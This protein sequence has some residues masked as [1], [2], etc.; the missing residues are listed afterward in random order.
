M[1]I[2]NIKVYVKK[3]ELVID[4]GKPIKLNKRFSDA[5][6]ENI[7]NSSDKALNPIYKVKNSEEFE[8]ICDDGGNIYEELAKH[9]LEEKIPISTQ[10]NPN[11]PFATLS[12]TG[13][14]TPKISKE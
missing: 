1:P 12:L 3:R 4:I 10:Y 14:F 6:Y 2:P 8:S 5:K 7:K 11:N 9:G 13:Y